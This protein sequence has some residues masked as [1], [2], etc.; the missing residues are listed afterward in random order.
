MTNAIQRKV[1]LEKW[2][3]G[4]WWLVD[5]KTEEEIDGHKYKYIVLDMAKRWNYKIVQTIN[6]CI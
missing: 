1:R 6:K 2:E 5:A 4:F 3:G